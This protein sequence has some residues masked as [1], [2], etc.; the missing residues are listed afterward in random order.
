MMYSWPLNGLKKIMYAMSEGERYDMKNLEDKCSHYYVHVKEI[1]HK[2]HLP[3]N[4]KDVTKLT[5]PVAV[6]YLTLICLDCSK[7]W[8]GKRVIHENIEIRVGKA[9]YGIKGFIPKYFTEIKPSEC[10]H[11]VFSVDQSIN[12][13]E[14]WD[15]DDPAKEYPLWSFSQALCKHCNNKLYVKRRYEKKN[16][17]NQFVTGSEWIRCKLRLV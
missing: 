17:M 16:E 10:E 13:V 9:T 15:Y 12:Y 11:P 3:I 8:N 5:Q 1:Y 14:T 4:F 6:E 7:T 2:E